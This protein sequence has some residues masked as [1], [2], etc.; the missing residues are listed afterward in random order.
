[1]KQNS[2]CRLLIAFVLFAFIEELLFKLLISVF[3]HRTR[4]TSGE[5]LRTYCQ[6]IPEL[7]ANIIHIELWVLI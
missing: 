3:I 5:R 6:V 7:F 1:M 2:R 4:S